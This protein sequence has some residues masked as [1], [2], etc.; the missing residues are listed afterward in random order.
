MESFALTE[1]RILA[2][3]QIAVLPHSASI[4]EEEGD[5]F[6]GHGG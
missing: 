5:V 2:L 4:T 6:G 3:K 1:E